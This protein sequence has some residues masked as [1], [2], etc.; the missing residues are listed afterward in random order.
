VPA[1]R[2]VGGQQPPRD[3]DRQHPD[4]DV[5]KE[6]EPPA[7]VCPAQGEQSAA[8]QRTEGGGD[9]TLVTQDAE[10]PAALAAFQVKGIGLD[11]RGAR[12]VLAVAPDPA[13]AAKLSVARS[14]SVL[15]KASRQRNTEAWAERLRTI[16]ADEFLRPL[17]T[18]EQAMGRQT[19][20]R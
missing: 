13:T 10:R 20:A 2:R 11:S 6:H 19:L 18:V 8:D 3:Q 7:L 12:A 9:P 1:E 16:F 17:P 15:C 4:R 14:G 5:D